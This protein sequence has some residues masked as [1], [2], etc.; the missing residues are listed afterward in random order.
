MPVLLGVDDLEPGMVLVNNIYNEFSVLLPH[1]RKL[2][3]YDISALRRKFPEIM[4]QVIDPVLDELV[5]FDD[6][7]HDREVATEVRKNIA[8]VS[9]K[10]SQT[11]R[12]GVE[13][14]GPNVAGIQK[15]IEEMMDYLENNPVTMAIIEQSNSWSDYLQE[16]SA[17]VFYLSLV[18]GNTIRNY[19]KQ[20]RERLSAA[21][22]IHNAMNLTPLAT[23]AL[24]HDIGMTPIE[25]VYKKQDPLTKEEKQ[26]IRQHPV[27]GAEMLPEQIDPMVRL[28]VRCHHEN[29]NGSGYP[30]GLSGDRI[31][32]F[33]RIMRIAD[34]YAAATAAKA[35]QKAKSA[36][37]VLHE[38]LNG[39][40]RVF[41]DPVVLKV[42]ASI[43]QPLPIGAKLRLDSGR[44]AVVVRHNQGRPFQPDLIVAF[45][46]LGDPLTNDQLIG[47]FPLGQRPDIKV[48]TFG[49][50]DVSFL[51]ELCNEEAQ[52]EPEQLTQSAGDL[53]DFVYP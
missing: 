8:T 29:Q 39:P 17:N 34:A 26:A 7:R 4:I 51:N 5:E 50:E 32:I 9:K 24:F 40:Y 42:F 27:R 23:A 52:L 41:Y 20:E 48:V 30:E 25:H 28:V 36:L 19:V 10:V 53:L 15:V 2:T 31:N 44:W 14:K 35:Y 11:L 18:M 49:D 43:M 47:P 37:Q 21:K 1:G 22:S 46:E 3:E 38:M 33:A 45:D 13:L 16:H 6:D 12:S